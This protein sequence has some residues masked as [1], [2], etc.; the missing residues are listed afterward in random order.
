MDYEWRLRLVMAQAGMF[1]ATDLTP[2]LAAHGM[3]LSEWQVLRLGKGMCTP[4]NLSWRARLCESFE[5][6]T[7]ALIVLTDTPVA[8]KRSSNAKG[9]PALG[10][11]LAPRQV[12]LQRPAR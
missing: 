10:K 6:H 2:K 7:G 3:V 5:C 1:K 11:D 9:G 12:K 4:A 8:R